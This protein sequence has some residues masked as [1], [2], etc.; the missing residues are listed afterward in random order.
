MALPEHPNSRKPWTPEETEKLRRLAEAGHPP[1]VIARRLGRSG[2]SVS[3][4]AEKLRVSIG[5]NSIT[6]IAERRE[7]RRR[8]AEEQA[9][10]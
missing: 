3:K 5:R 1:S 4:Q 2:G 7:A 9:S 8:D 6:R 10:G